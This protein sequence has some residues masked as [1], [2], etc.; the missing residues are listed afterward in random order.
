MKHPLRRAFSA[1]TC[2]LFGL[3]AYLQF[4]DPDPL[5]WILYYGGVCVLGGLG[6]AGIYSRWLGGVLTAAGAVWS[7]TLS[8]SVVTWLRG[9]TV[10]DIVYA[11]SPDRPYIEESRECLGLAMAAAA[12]ALH[13]WW[14]LRKPKPDEG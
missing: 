6:V 2:A 7:L 9:H 11:M 8:P 1:L 14:S 12:C 4:N 10:S 3:T 13:L 5:L